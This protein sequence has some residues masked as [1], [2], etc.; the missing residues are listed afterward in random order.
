MSK[1]QLLILSKM[2]KSQKKKLCSAAKCYFHL[3]ERKMLMVERGNICLCVYIFRVRTAHGQY[4]K[5]AYDD[6]NCL[7]I[8]RVLKGGEAA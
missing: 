5:N 2:K 3:D 6:V 4:V 1:E 8:K 7:Q